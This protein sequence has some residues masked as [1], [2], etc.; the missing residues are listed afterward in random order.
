MALLS[1]LDGISYV[2]IVVKLCIFVEII[3]V[4]SWVHL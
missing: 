3:V 2:G 1:S 4:S